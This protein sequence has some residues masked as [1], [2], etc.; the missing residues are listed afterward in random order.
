[1]KP[2]FDFDTQ[3]E[4][5]NYPDFQDRVWFVPSEKSWMA[6][7][8]NDGWDHQYDGV[9]CKQTG[10]DFKPIALPPTDSRYFNPGFWYNLHW[11]FK[12]GELGAWVD[13]K[14]NT[15]EFITKA[16]IISAIEKEA[17]K[18]LGVTCKILTDGDEI[19]EACVPCVIGEEAGILVW[20]SCD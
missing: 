6:D 18:L 9:C 5:K 1:M 14:K 4:I 3:I 15:G 20:E 8:V 12:N 10:F 7:K 16:Q 11:D 2:N 13:G 17:E 19:H